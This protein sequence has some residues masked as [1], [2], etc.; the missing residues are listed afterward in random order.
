MLSSYKNGT[1]ILQDTRR[2]GSFGIYILDIL[3]QLLNNIILYIQLRR[4]DTGADSAY[5]ANAEEF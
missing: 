1:E 3:M 2:T 4:L 5:R